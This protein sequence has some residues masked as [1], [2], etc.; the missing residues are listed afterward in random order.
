MFVE[1]HMIQN[2]APSCLNRDDT[3]S[4]KDC[5]F[6]G[7]RR[8][9][10]SSQCIKR[11]IRHHPDFAAHVATG[12]G[13]RTKLLVDTLAG[14]L[15][16][17]GKPDTEATTVS[18]AVVEA[19]VGT[20][21]GDKTAV[22]IYLGDDEVERIRDI[23][24]ER[25]DTLAPLAAEQETAD[26]TPQNEEAP[27][28]RGKKAKAKT[29]PLQEAAAEIKKEFNSGTRAA[30]IALFGRMVAENTNM[31]VDAAC[32]VAHAIS[33]H[34]ASMEMD[35]Y[36]AV[37]DL[38]PEEDPGAGMMGTVEFN[39]S[40]FYR[41]SLIDLDKLIRNLGDDADLA[42]AIV[43]AFIR[44]AVA[45]IPTG[46]QNSMA[47]QNPPSFVFAVVRDG[48]APWSLANAFEKPVFPS[49]QRGGL[50]E[51]SISALDDY[52]G[53]LVGMYGDN[54]ARALAFC[55]LE[56]VDLKALNGSRADNVE[57]LVAAVR[58]AIAGGA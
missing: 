7:F 46:K 4:P 23:V 30:D 16:E 26:E 13:V 44:A 58:E 29:G 49:P 18:R 19:L 8:A 53:R 42:R 9:R 2:F 24:L 27:A 17:A 57:A 12:I 14:A 25:W 6:G 43:E 39:S 20:M 3:N 11:S 45:A 22:L 38:Q 36:T 37:D 51:Q 55:C 54:G 10:I 48:G 56:D 52:W 21:Q 1:L 32:Q 31:N 5:D 50:V 33:T 34:R 47:A 41:Y 40:C 15:V 28:R 35:F